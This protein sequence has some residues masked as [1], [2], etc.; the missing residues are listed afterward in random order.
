[1]PPWPVPPNEGFGLC[2]ISLDLESA[3]VAEELDCGGDVVEVVSAEVETVTGWYRSTVVGSDGVW[4][5]MRP[6]P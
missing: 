6:V 2:R 4:N 1:M 5:V 3:F